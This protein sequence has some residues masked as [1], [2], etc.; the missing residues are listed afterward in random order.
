MRDS[1]LGRDIDLIDSEVVLACGEHAEG[2]AGRQTP[3]LR[4]LD[5]DHEESAGL[6]VRGRA[7]KARHLCCLGHQILNGVVDEIYERERPVDGRR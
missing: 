1:A 6:Q 7:P 2:I 5:L 3:E 4:H